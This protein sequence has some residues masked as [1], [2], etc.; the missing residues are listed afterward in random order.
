MYQALAGEIPWTDPA[1]VRSIETWKDMRAKGYWM[2]GVDRFF[3]ATFDEF[4]A[5]FAAGEAAMNLEGTW[6]FG[7][8][9]EYFTEG[10]ED[11][12]DWVPFPSESGEAVS[13]L[14]IGGARALNRNSKDP[15][16]AAE[17]LTYELSPEV[18]ARFL[19]D[20]GI[21]PAPVRMDASMLEGLDPRMAR[22][23]DEFAQAQAECNYDYTVWTF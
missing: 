8:I 3:D 18:Q 4:S 22:L 21:A 5:A 19:M 17:W 20:C 14:D 9:P 11:D 6:F 1:F 10:H 12:W 15:Q 7:R 16:A 13:S 2:G 23:Y